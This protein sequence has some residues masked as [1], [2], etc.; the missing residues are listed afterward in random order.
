MA[1]LS[2]VSSSCYNRYDACVISLFSLGAGTCF[3][4]GSNGHLGRGGRGNTG[5][6]GVAAPGVGRGAGAPFHGPARGGTGPVRVRGLL[7]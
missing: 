6:R 2:D 5:I 3:P 1:T 4:C 7:S